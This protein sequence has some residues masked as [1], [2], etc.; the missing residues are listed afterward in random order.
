MRRKKQTNS[1]QKNQAPSNSSKKKEPSPNVPNEKQVKVNK[2][3][4]VY[5]FNPTTRL[6]D[7]SDVM[8]NGLP[9]GVWQNEVGMIVAE[10]KIEGIDRIELYSATGEKFLI[11][12]V[13]PTTNSSIKWKP[14]TDK[15]TVEIKGDVRCF[16]FNSPD[17]RT[18]LIPVR[19]NIKEIKTPKPKYN[20]EVS[21]DGNSFFDNLEE[22]LKRAGFDTLS[23]IGRNAFADALNMNVSPAQN[24][25][26]KIFF[27]RIGNDPYTIQFESTIRAGNEPRTFGTNEPF[28]LNFD[29]NVTFFQYPSANLELKNKVFQNISQ[30]VSRW[31]IQ[32][33]KIPAK[34]VLSYWN[35]YVERHYDS[36]KTE[37]GGLPVSFLPHFDEPDNQARRRSWALSYLIG[38]ASIRDSENRLDYI[39][40]DV[41]KSLVVKA[42][43][44]TVS[45]MTLRPIE[46]QTLNVSF[47]QLRKH[48]DQPLRATITLTTADIPD[49][50]VKEDGKG[51]F[52]SL[53]KPVS[54][55]QSLETTTVR[56]GALDLE[57]GSDDSPLKQANSFRILPYQN[58]FEVHAKSSMFAI[59]EIRAGGQDNIIGEDFVPENSSVSDFERCSIGLNDGQ[60]LFE[61]EGLIN[62]PNKLKVKLETIGENNIEA[63]FRRKRPLVIDPQLARQNIIRQEVVKPAK[64]FLNVNEDTLKGSSHTIRLKLL[65]AEQNA[66]NPAP[67]ISFDKSAIILDSDPF[68][69]AKVRF[70]SFTG[71]SEFVIGNWTNTG[72]EGTNWQLVS[73]SEPFHLILPPQGI[74]EEMEKAK[75]IDGLRPID[76]RLSPP[77]DITLKGSENAQNFTEPPWNLRRLMGFHGESGSGVKIDQLQF[78]LMYGLSCDSKHPFLRLAEISSIIGAIQGRLPKDPKAVLSETQKLYYKIARLEWA[79]LFR[80]YLSRIAILEPFDSHQP[81]HLLLSQNTVCRI[82]LNLDNKDPDYILP[83][84]EMAPPVDGAPPPLLPTPTPTPTPEPST[85][86]PIPSTTPLPTVPPLLKGGITWGFESK[87]V[88]NAVMKIKSGEVNPTSDPAEINDVYFS[89]FGGW[90]QIKAP[91]DDKKSTLYADVAMGRTY[92]YK[93]ERIGRISCFWN[94]AKHVI[95]YERTVVPTTQMNSLQNPLK[96]RP[97]LRK[98][99]EYVE[100]LEDVRNF[101]DGENPDSDLLKQQRGFV[102]ACSFAKGAKFNVLSS[103]GTDVG[104]IGWKVPL[105]DPSTKEPDIYPKPKVHLNLI[106]AIAEKSTPVPCLIGNPENIYFYTQTGTDERHPN[107]WAPVKNVDFV[108]LPKPQPPADFKDGKNKQTT[109]PDSPSHPGFSCCTYTIESNGI[110]TDMIA[111]RAGKPLSAVVETITMMRAR[112]NDLNDKTVEAKDDLAEKLINLRQNATQAFQELLRMI[113]IDDTAAQNQF[114]NLIAM[115]ADKVTDKFNTIKAD[116]EAFEKDFAERRKSVFSKL[117]SYENNVFD[118]L[119]KRLTEDKNGVQSIVTIVRQRYNEILIIPDLT[120][121]QRAAQE[122]LQNLQDA[123]ILLDASPGLLTKTF[124]QYIEAYL[125]WASESEDLALSIGS[126]INSPS[127][128]NELSGQLFNEFQLFVRSL[129]QLFDALQARIKNGIFRPAEAWLPDPYEKL[130]AD[131]FSEIEKQWQT[132]RALLDQVLAAAGK[133]PKREALEIIDFFTGEWQA[134]L[135]FSELRLFTAGFPDPA[136]YFDYLSKAEL[137]ESGKELSGWIGEQLNEINK[138]NDTLND[139]RDRVTTILLPRINGTVSDTGSLLWNLEQIKKELFPEEKL[140]VLLDLGFDSVIRT[141]AD[142]KGQIDNFKKSIL[143]F[144]NRNPLRQSLENLRDGFINKAEDFVEKNIHSLLPPDK[145]KYSTP[146]SVARLIRA[147]GHPPEVPNLTFD[148]EQIAYYFKEL[149]QSVGLTPVLSRVKQASAI[150]DDLKSIGI[151]LPTEKIVDK[152]VPPELK[153]FSLSEILPNV[154]GLDLSNLF[155]GLKMPEMGNE[156]VEIKHG[157]DL[158]SRRAWV[159]TKVHLKITEPATVFSIGPVIL[160]LTSAVFAANVR[161]EAAPNQ[162]PQRVVNGSIRGNWELIIGEIPLVIFKDTELRFDDGGKFRFDISPKNVELPEILA[163]VSEFLSSF[164]SPDS[165]FSVG[166]TPTGV[167]ALLNLPIPDIQSGAFG[168]SNLVLGMAFGL[169]FADEFKIFISFSLG[170]KE[171]PFALVI[172]LLGG[173]GYIENVIEYTPGTGALGCRVEVGITACASVAI[174]IGP[175]KGGVYVYFG[176]FAN[177]ALSNNAAD[178]KGLT[179]GVML[180][181]RGEVCILGLANACIIQLLEARYRGGEIIGRGKFSIKIK[182][183]WC[184]TLKVEREIEYKLT[185]GNSAQN[186]ENN[187]LDNQTTGMLRN[188]RPIFSKLE[189]GN[190]VQFIKT[191]YTIVPE[192]PLP[193][194]PDYAADYIL[195]LS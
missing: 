99:E 22:S 33:K 132:K 131:Y 164:S 80:R 180:L 126:K 23:G 4:A 104:T 123:L 78:E 193:D 106:S 12:D 85:T 6:H 161:F 87:N 76:F 143:S 182:I 170:R 149:D 73:R 171:A 188:E 144:S 133:F 18:G 83:P 130:F 142:L 69:V 91:F 195:M 157:F 15:G 98:T 3:V 121:A 140:R 116:I 14:N 134:N 55:G 89:S 136:I 20:I 88:Y 178:N 135:K 67:H 155:S 43:K 111:A 9:E 176:V 174:A 177:L 21:T 26:L 65:S 77:A 49:F 72:N 145:L 40:S 163:F 63:H 47:Y 151:A 191:G 125:H 24:V 29:E 102:S 183:C 159:E 127:T 16:L 141:I 128:P 30:P 160:R 34:D 38:D 32:I 101:P 79:S 107:K 192:I 58:I 84:A 90:G 8:F 62:D 52:F 41:A 82:R 190:S 139:F 115:I 53:T 94:Q 31:V 57:F 71:N 124:R 162:P 175:I 11:I 158:Q 118:R 154:A 70:K 42:N 156:N 110:P 119:T 1:V 138:P 97:I 81:E 54:T 95:V 46:N 169:D 45:A 17:S 60:I 39:Y 5:K 35:E 167:Q 68:L 7:E 148:R 59:A 86:C 165:G 100:I 96:G 2:L 48:D 166:L 152:L 108:D 189:N 181:M 137:N 66:P 172:F 93:I 153:N 185:G 173:G 129:I 168:I 117:T 150:A 147:F 105:W 184:F 36:L 19:I 10:P 27:A 61:L 103:W 13:L 37:L 75:T 112:L 74:G 50:E 51:I 113:P 92:K 194:E 146:D 109:P 64:Y 56:M 186:R 122:N 179:I 25:P 28:T 114:S 120:A 187:R 44:I